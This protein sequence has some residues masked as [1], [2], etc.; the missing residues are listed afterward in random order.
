MKKYIFA[1]AAICS[2]YFAQAQV[3]SFGPTVGFNYAWL[4]DLDNESGRPSFNAGFTYNYSILQS[5]G[6]GIEARYS[7]EGVKQDIGNATLTTK[8]NYI[9]VP[10]KFQYFFGE[11]GDNFR[12]KIFAGPSFAFLMGGKSEIRAGETT[13]TIDSKDVFEGFDVGLL[14]GLGFN[15][16]LA[17]RT[18]LNFDV[19]YTHGML[20]VA[21]SNSGSDAKNRLVNVNVGVAFGFGE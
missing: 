7:E 15:Y 4:S 19:A 2:G 5:A 12:P 17:E 8:L 21:G 3:Q 13:T 14:G 18:W 20:D 1:L 9:R 10:L 11:L 16:R 6:L